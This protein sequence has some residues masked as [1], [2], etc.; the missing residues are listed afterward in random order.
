MAMA[1][2]M[3]TNTSSAPLPA[4]RSANSRAF[5]N[6]SSS[7]TGR[8]LTFTATP[9]TGTGYAGFTRH[10]SLEMTTNLTNPSAWTPVPAYENIIA[11][12]QVIVI[13]PAPRT[14]PTFYRLKAW[15][16]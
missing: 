3:Q 12:N 14:T 11:T 13:S 16:Q 9:T 7:G 4:P 8:V 10:Y 2:Q 5:L 1:F 15:L 6:A